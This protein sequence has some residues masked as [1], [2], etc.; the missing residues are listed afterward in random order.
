MSRHEWTEEEHYLV[1]NTY[2]DEVDK[3]RRLTSSDKVRIVEHVND[4]VDD[5]DLCGSI[6]MLMQNLSHILIDLGHPY[7]SIFSPRENVG[8]TFKGRLKALIKSRN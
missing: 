2:L 8:P 1:I 5:G 6:S 7:L 3:G 4:I